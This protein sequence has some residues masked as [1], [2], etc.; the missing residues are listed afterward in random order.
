MSGSLLTCLV[1]LL[2]VANGFGIQ[3]ESGGDITTISNHI[4]HN[5]ISELEAHY[6]ANEFIDI[7]YYDCNMIRD[8]LIIDVD[9]NLQ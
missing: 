5:L 1:C 7:L 2:T 6:S 8:A 3:E 4:V 9:N